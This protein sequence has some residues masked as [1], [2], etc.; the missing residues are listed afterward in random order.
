VATSMMKGDEMLVRRS[1]EA[2]INHA[3]HAASH[4]NTK[5]STFNATETFAY[6]RQFVEL[7]GIDENLRPYMN[8]YGQQNESA[9]C[10]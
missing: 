8:G 6:Q 10:V 3:H 2:S 7:G 4:A 9:A 1:G 5:Y